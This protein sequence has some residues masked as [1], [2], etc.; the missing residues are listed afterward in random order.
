MLAVEWA[1]DENFHDIVGSMLLKDLRRLEASVPELETG[2]TYY[3][4]V[5]AGSLGGFGEPTPSNPPCAT[6]SSMQTCF[7][8]IDYH[9]SV[10]GKISTD[11]TLYTF[12]P[13]R[14]LLAPRRL[15]SRANFSS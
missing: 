5:T 6:V 3:V 13:M 1:R 4:R 9:K 10:R 2:T 11:Y 7:P 12:P 15:G 14:S 8:T